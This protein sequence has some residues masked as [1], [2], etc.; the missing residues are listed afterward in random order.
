LTAFEQRVIHVESPFLEKIDFIDKHIDNQSIKVYGDSLL[1]V[2][3]IDFELSDGIILLHSEKYTTVT[4]EYI[5]YPESLFK[6]YRLYE[7]FDMADSTKVEAIN[8]NW[9]KLLSERSKLNITGSKTVS[10][11]VSNTSNF[12][13]N[14]SLYLRIDGELSSNVFIKAQLND[15]QS[16][17]T[18]EGNTRE[19]SSLDEVYLSVYGKQYEVA[20]GD[21]QFD[22]QNTRF[23]NYSQKYEG[24][25]LS[26]FPKSSR[27][28]FG[29]ALSNSK[30]TYTTFSGIE[31]K[32]GPYFLR[33]SGVYSTVQVIEGSETIWLNGRQL[34][35]GTDYTIDYNEGFI[36]FSLSHFISANSRVQA[37]FQYTDEY[38][39]KNTIM[40][41]TSIDITQRLQV[42]ASAIYQNDDKDYPLSDYFSDK[43][44]AELAI[45]SGVEAIYLS[46]ETFVGSGE[47]NYRMVGDVF[48][49]APSKEDAY[50][51][52]V[53]TY[54]GEGQGN[55]KQISVYHFDF[56]G[57]GQGAW[58]PIREV[59]APQRKANYDFSLHYQGDVLEFYTESLVSEYDKNTFSGVGDERKNSQVH[60]FQM[61]YH[62]DFDI[63]AP[64][65]T[66]WYRYRQRDLYTFATILNEDESYQ[67]F[68]FT[69]IDTLNS[70][71][72][73]IALKT[74][75]YDFFTQETQIKTI[76]FDKKL[77]QTYI[78]AFQSVKQSKYLPYLDYRYHYAENMDKVSAV[79][80]KQK[81]LIHEP[82]TKYTL[83]NLNWQANAQYIQQ[84]SYIDDMQT[85]QDGNRYTKYFTEATLAKLLYSTLSTSYTQD[86]NHDFA[87]DDWIKERNSQTVTVQSET[88][89]KKHQFTALY[90]HRVVRHFTDDQSKQSFDIADITT[91]NEIL[92]EGILLSGN[93]NLKNTEF[94]PRFRELVYVGEGLGV[95]DSTGVFT[96]NGDYEY[97]YALSNDARHSI[98]VSGKMTAYTYPA[99]FYIPKGSVKDFLQRV[100]LETNVAIT[101][102]TEN[103][104]KWKVYLLSPNAINNDKSIYSRQEHRE[105]VWYNIVP[106]K[107][108]SRF[109]YT[110]TSTID[111]RYSDSYTQ[112][113]TMS[114]NEIALRLLRW[115]NSDYEATYKWRDEYDNQYVLDS[116][117]KKVGLNIRTAPSKQLIFTTDLGFERETNV[118][119]EDSQEIDGYN[120]GENI[121]YFIGQK[122]RMNVLFTLKYNDISDPLLSSV[123]TDKTAGTF[124]SWQSGVEYRINKISTLNLSY[125]GYKNPSV[126]EAFHQVKMEVRAEF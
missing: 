54:V 101:E 27:T 107:W 1:L 63:I 60:H 123:P 7:P 40:G 38:Y 110:R 125:S 62:P 89:Y 92:D 78:N 26:Y 6:A 68:A 81:L 31:G 5:A 35:R 114:E 53:F 97:E 3:D 13:L 82:T 43:D 85:I 112:S 111:R 93:Y 47:G 25:K 119:L 122:Y 42:Q 84:L 76:D 105:T 24:L 34:A 109:T 77:R 21:L 49:Y 116:H 11:S 87:N 32:Q 44:K 118:I 94:F 106:N 39:R 59:I 55:Y 50:Y 22:I 80:E 98:E 72:Y 46:G 115:G 16:P 113:Q 52:V 75:T 29:V 14:Q 33:P 71:E 95:C 61:S 96:D 48:E 23:I 4:I 2:R 126:T 88:N 58:L 64:T 104:D 102:H 99:Q 103:T 51:D 57:V 9:D 117:S 91:K 12:D 90:S 83:G 69:P 100:N 15:S 36:D 56:V 121:L 45:S 30:S 70:H 67:Q 18:P 37:S 74:L 66:A 65:L 8:T 28:A 120:F 19:L 124:L 73:N 79:S 17:I 20:F 108:I 10:I 41:S 86:E